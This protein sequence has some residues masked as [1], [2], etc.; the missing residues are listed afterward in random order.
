MKLIKQTG[1]K[2]L[3]YC[4][5][6]KKEFER[7]ISAGRNTKTCSEKCSIMYKS[8]GKTGLTF[9]KLNN[10]FIIQFIIDGVLHYVG[11]YKNKKTALLDRDKYVYQQGLSH[12]FKYSQRRTIKTLQEELYAVTRKK[13]YNEKYRTEEHVFR[14][15]SLQV[16]RYDN[17][18]EQYK[19][20]KYPD[21]ELN[22]LLQ[23]FKE[24]ED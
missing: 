16:D 8:N 4:P 10:S 22:N 23:Q 6:C 7:G 12:R 5:V 20:S 15:S 21:A 24:M 9:N 1:K 14:S 17:I 19:Q 13:A 11:S 18:E 2:G 3:F